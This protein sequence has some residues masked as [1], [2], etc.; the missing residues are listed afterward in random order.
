[1]PMQNFFIFTEAQRNTALGLDADGI[2]EIDPRAVDGGSPSAG[3]NLN[4]VA[5]G[6]DPGEAV[7]L[8]GT[9]VA[10][11]RIVDDPVYQ[12]HCPG[13]I[14]FLQTLPWASLQT[15]TIF[16]PVID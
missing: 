3:A 15:E 6:Y 10:P 11:H 1:M 7:P 5:T 13:L 2:A 16:A 12:S 14:A 9:Y 4:D 8:T